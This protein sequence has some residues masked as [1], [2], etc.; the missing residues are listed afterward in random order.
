MLLHYNYY[1]YN[2]VFVVA[3]TAVVSYLV[4]FVVAVAAFLLHL[5]L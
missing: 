5:L 4:A 2:H 3:V 1:G